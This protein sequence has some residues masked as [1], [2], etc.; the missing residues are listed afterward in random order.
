MNNR[1]PQGKPHISYPTRKPREAVL[2]G[3]KLNVLAWWKRV[4]RT[5]KVGALQNPFHLPS[6]QLPH[7]SFG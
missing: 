1:R 6:V 4:K 3:S 7:C 5:H 2:N